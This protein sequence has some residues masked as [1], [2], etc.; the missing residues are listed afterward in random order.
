MSSATSTSLSVPKSIFKNSTPGLVFGVT[1]L[2]FLSILFFSVLD[3][4][5]TGDDVRGFPIG[6]LSIGDYGCPYLAS[7]LSIIAC[8]NF[9]NLA[10]SALPRAFNC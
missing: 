6:V 5:I 7:C 8:F 10:S 4:D 3:L 1:E 9:S 2:T